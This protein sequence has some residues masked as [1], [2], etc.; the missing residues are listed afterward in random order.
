MKKHPP[1]SILLVCSFFLHWTSSSF[2]ICFPFMV[3][4]RQNMRPTFHGGKKHWKWELLWHRF[5][6]FCSNIYYGTLDMDINNRFH[7]EVEW[8]PL[9]L[10]EMPK[11]HLADV[12]AMEIWEFPPPP[13]Q[14]PRFLINS[15]QICLPLWCCIRDIR[16][17]FISDRRI[18]YNPH[19]S[20]LLWTA[21]PYFC[22]LTKWN[23]FFF[24]KKKEE[25]EC[26]IKMGCI[27]FLKC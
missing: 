6:W 17:A 19:Q 18:S 1:L 22:L 27:I 23:G 7:E 21:N 2:H 24:F 10:R 5:H 14:Q 4:Q 11:C 26:K 25:K 13:S 16:Q 15:N 12:T 20:Y 3:S 8:P 9:D